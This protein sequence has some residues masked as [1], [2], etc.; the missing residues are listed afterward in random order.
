MGKKLTGFIAVTL[1]SLLKLY[2]IAGGAVVEVS[3]I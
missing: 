2:V 3:T 1:T